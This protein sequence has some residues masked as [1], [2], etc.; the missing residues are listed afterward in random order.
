MTTLRPFAAACFGLLC[1][2]LAGACNAPR[3]E[4]D[5][6]AADTLATDTLLAARPPM[7]WNSWDSFGVDVSEAEYKQNVDF[8]AER[9]QPLGWTYAVVDLLWYGGPDVTIHTFKQDRPEQRMD[10]YGRLLPAENRFPSAGAEGSFKPVADYVHGKGLKFGIHIMRGIPWQAVEQNTPILGTNYRARDIAALQDTCAW[11]DGMYGV[12]MTKPGA[13]EYYDSLARLYAEWGVDYVKADDMSYPY[14]AAEIEGLS[15]ALR[16]TGRPIVLSLSPGA[17]P[18]EQA[19]HLRAHAN[20]WRISADFWDAWPLLRKQFDLCK[21]WEGK[22][23]PGAWPDADM[24]PLG[25]LRKHGPDDYLLEAFNAEGGRLRAAD[26]TDED[27]RFTPEEQRTMMTLWSVF[28]SPLMYGGHLPES[29][30]AA[31]ALITNPEVI[32]VN[33]EGRNPREVYRRGDAVVWASE[34][35][36]D[37]TLHVALFNLGEGAREV[38]ATWQEL[39]L[40][41]MYAVR[42]VWARRDASAEAAQ[43][44][45]TLPAHG[46]GLYRLTRR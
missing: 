17:A 2:T 7:G 40:S 36:E 8:M 15:Q 45:A 16:K 39:G 44:R 29:D 14:H 5:R 37:G 23:A 32:A 21:T 11:Y 4:N 46:A 33:Q 3:P 24:L 41:G 6:A 10:A 26:V 13:Q 27:S 1:L 30:S 38:G 9:L 12:D 42:D 19:D 35:A 28:R 18:P 31:L 20:L 22:G 34:G 43:L 25:R